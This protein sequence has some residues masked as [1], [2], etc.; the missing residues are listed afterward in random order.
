[1]KIY[2]HIWSAAGAAAA[3][4]LATRSSAWASDD[5]DTVT[6]VVPFDLSVDGRAI[7][8]KLGGQAF[9]QTL[10]A[11]KPF[12]LDVPV[13]KMSGAV[14]T[15]VLDIWP[16]PAAGCA[17]AQPPTTG[18]Q[19]YHLAMSI[20]GDRGSEKLHA[21]VPVLQIGQPFC[22][23]L[24]PQVAMS[25]NERH[26]V[27]I[28]FASRVEDE[29]SKRAGDEKSCDA[30]LGSD[31]GARALLKPLLPMF[32][33]ESIRYV[34]THLL[35]DRQKCEDYAAKWKLDALSSETRKRLVSDNQKFDNFFANRKEPRY[36]YRSWTRS[37]VQSKEFGCPTFSTE[38]K[39]NDTLELS[40]EA[41]PSQCSL[42]SLEANCTASNERKG[43]L[44]KRPP[45][46][47]PSSPDAWKT[48][49]HKDEP[50]GQLV[51]FDENGHTQP[52]S[53]F[54]DLPL[55]TDEKIL[56]DRQQQVALL[57]RAFA[58]ANDQASMLA[59]LRARFQAV[60]SAERSKSE[61]AL[62]E[63]KRA[64]DESVVTS[65]DG[66]AVANRLAGFGPSIDTASTVGSGTPPNQGNY[67]MV[68]AGLLLAWPRTP[69]DVKDAW[70]VPY[71]GVNIYFVP[72]D[73]N[74]PVSEFV[75]STFWQRLSLTLGLGLTKPQIAG[76]DVTP[77]VGGAV[78]VLAIGWRVGQ[79]TRLTAGSA[80]YR[81]RSETAGS[82]AEVVGWA[83]GIGGSLD[84]DVIHTL[85]GAAK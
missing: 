83:P 11:G 9:D 58:D 55:P 1:M 84:W 15:A 64:F 53:A 81:V 51:L 13:S 73:R 34:A 33:D 46:S 54:F 36:A 16:R 56:A 62:K 7:P 72:V 6:M 67:V 42:S 28:R 32:D 12:Y 63:A 2:R 4:V 31:P 20:T 23:R 29:V 40:D 69:S 75:G 57:I 74:V 43:V 24:T 8:D 35:V 59:I 71:G 3:L 45:A 39:L 27:A 82:E 52:V 38:T 77:L 10:P 21:K 47:K 19:V 22:F 17:G 26:D 44:N 18:R 25:E 66:A 60:S 5:V 70:A 48:A 78:G 79:Y 30:V 61:D 37:I 41:W 85:E 49:C 68:D 80:F 65:F 76:R 50:V 14:R